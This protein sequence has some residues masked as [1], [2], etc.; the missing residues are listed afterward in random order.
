M[1]EVPA[2]EGLWRHYVA[3]ITGAD[4]EENGLPCQDAFVVEQDSEGR[5]VAIV[6]DGAGSA[7]HGDVGAQTLARLLADSLLSCLS[8]QEDDFEL[9][10]TSVRL[11]IERGIEGVR[12]TLYE[13]AQRDGGTLSDYHATLVGVLATTKG[14]ALLHIGDGAAIA[15]SGGDESS[16]VSE[17]ENGEYDNETFFFTMADW[18]Q[19]LRID[20]IP[21]TFNTFL[22]MSDGV[23]PVALNRDGRSPS[24]PFV[25]PISRYLAACAPTIG[26]EALRELLT[27]PAMRTITG[28]DKL[29]SA[30]AIWGAG[31]SGP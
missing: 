7:R 5:F 26:D 21:A 10:P 14:G 8:S 11:W 22:V 23:T 3:C 18:R 13:V 6:A 19:H 24:R 15:L 20:I 27:R 29:S 28:E 2:K 9:D 16:I 4:H 25:D 31:C 1:Q 30:L 12:I 17:A